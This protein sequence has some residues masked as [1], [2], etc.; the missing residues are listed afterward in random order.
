MIKYTHNSEYIY[1]LYIRYNKCCCIVIE[2]YT[3]ALPST[4][5]VL[6]KMTNWSRLRDAETVKADLS[7]L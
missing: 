2:W 7:S 4:P 6:R 5:G 3:L 1:R